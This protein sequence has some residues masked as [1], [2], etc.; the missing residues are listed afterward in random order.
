MALGWLSPRKRAFGATC[1]EETS[2]LLRLVRHATAVVEALR[3]T[4]GAMPAPSAS[5]DRAYYERFYVDPKTRV[6][7]RAQLDK[8]GDFVCAYLRY[9][10]LPLKRVL[11]L[12]CGIGHWRSVLER[13]FPSARYQGVEYSE[14]LCERYGWERGSAVDYRSRYAFDLVICQGVLPYLDPRP[15]KQALENLATLCK[16]ALYLEAVTREDWEDGVV[17]KRRTDKKMQF[18]PAAFYRRALSPHFVNVGGGLWLSRRARVPTYA[19]ER[20]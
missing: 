3:A 15:A 20:A 8:L 4:L 2:T 17:D 5:F 11:D 7:D 16:G 18:R 19:L 9:L 13:Q 10:E 6:S 1:R 12:G 14:Y